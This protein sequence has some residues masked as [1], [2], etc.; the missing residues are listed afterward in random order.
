MQTQKKIRPLVRIKEKFQVTLPVE[1]RTR[2]G[3]AV[4]DFLEVSLEQGGVITLTPKSLVDRQIAEG[5]ADLKAGRI[6][7][8]YETAE[9]AISALDKRGSKKSSVR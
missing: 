5:L 2:S 1:L 6:H 3:L 7:G 9:E 4:G 8:P